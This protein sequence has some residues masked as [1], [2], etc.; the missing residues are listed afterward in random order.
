[1]KVAPQALQVSLSRWERAGVRET[2]MA[3]V[4][5]M[6]RGGAGAMTISTRAWT[7]AGI[8]AGFAAGPG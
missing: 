8:A 6:T 4:P 7:D 3:P 5:F 1:M 2:V